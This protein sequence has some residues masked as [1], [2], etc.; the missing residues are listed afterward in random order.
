MTADLSLDFNKSA[1]TNDV[2][3][4]SDFENALQSDQ[5]FLRLKKPEILQVVKVSNA[6]AGKNNQKTS[7]L[8]TRLLKINFVTQNGVKVSG[9]E[10]GFLGK[11]VS[12]TGTA[13]GAKFEISG[14]V[15]YVN[16][17]LFLNAK[18]LKY[19]GGTVK[20][21]YDNWIA[22]KQYDEFN[23]IDDTGSK[24]TSQAPKWKPFNFRDQVSQKD[25]DQLSK[26]KTRDQNKNDRK[27]SNSLTEEENKQRMEALKQ[28][29]EAN[30]AMQPKFFV[31]L[32]AGGGHSRDTGSGN[33]ASGSGDHQANHNSQPNTPTL[34]LNINIAHQTR[35]G[36]RQRGGRGR[37]RGRNRDATGELS[38]QDERKY[39]VSSNDH[40]FYNESIASGL[41]DKMPGLSV[42]DVHEQKERHKH[43]PI[44][45]EDFHPGD[46]GGR[47]GRG[48]RGSRGGGR[49]GRG[50]SRGDRGRG[51]PPNS[52]GGYNSPGPSRGGHQDNYGPPRGG[53]HDRESRGGHRE[54]YGP[55]RGGHREHYRVL[56]DRKNE[57]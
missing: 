34:D 11:N 4:P 12:V 13:P 10:H 18:N 38:S 9:L 48:G 45:P 3:T 27:D 43:D 1:K 20:S 16:N 46:R 53:H 41:V 36:G 17:L 30:K 40:D 14:S 29:E 35:G 57:H 51:G 32:N 8:S 7:N 42:Y 2:V 31:R 24:T 50:G 55:P 47:G 6:G 39:M 25:I 28:A 33:Y 22:N 44:L 54:N 37:G 19:L 52:R 26:I 15:Q 56:F 5:K 21:L 49:G 23:E